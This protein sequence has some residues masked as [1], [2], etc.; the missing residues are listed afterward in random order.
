MSTN[1]ESQAERTLPEMM[2]PRPTGEED[3]LRAHTYSLLGALLAAPPNAE[4]IALLCQVE[5]RPQ[6]EGG[7]AL[8][9]QMLRLG[10]ERADLDQLD[11]EFHDLFIGIGTGEIVPYGSWYLTGFLMDRPL[12]QLRKDLDR[13]GIEREAD[14]HEPED[15]AAALCE[16]MALVINSGTEISFATQQ[17]FFGEHIAPWM[18]KFFRDLQEAKSARFYRAVGRLGEQFMEFET[19]YLAMPV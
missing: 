14:V 4:L 8:G 11:D 19:K 7:V 9:W 3:S 15:H 18:G 10:A 12:A 2:C 1:L 13:L 17:A 6:T 5:T 16:A